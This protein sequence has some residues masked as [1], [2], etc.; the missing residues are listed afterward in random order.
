MVSKLK[1]SSNGAL[2]ERAIQQY[3]DS[4]AEAIEGLSNPL[5][6]GR[7][8]EDVAVADATLKRIPHGLGRQYRGY[9]I[10]LSNGAISSHEADSTNPRKESELHLTTNG[11]ATSISIWIF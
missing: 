1:V 7:L 8:I 6:K 9:I 11:P 2:N 4:S 5:S 10:V 3:L